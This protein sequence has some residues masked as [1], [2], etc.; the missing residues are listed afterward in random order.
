MRRNLMIA[1]ACGVAMLASAAPAEMTVEDVIAKHVAARGGKEAWSKIETIKCTGTFTAFSEVD[2]FTMHK[3]RGDM[4]HMDHKLNGAPVL[5][6]NDGK[7]PWQDSQLF[8]QGGAQPLTGPD[9][10]AQLREFDFV[11]PLFEVAERGYAVEL[12]GETEY[13]GLPAI[14]IKLTRTDDSE[15][16]WYLDPETYL[17]MARTSPGSDFGRPM[18]QRTFFDDFRAVSG[19]MIPHLTETQWYTRDRVM[20]IETIEVNVPI[21]DALFRMPA[22]PGMADLIAIAGSFKVAVQQRQQP[23]APWQDS[24]STSKIDK[25]FNG[26][27]MRGFNTTGGGTEIH[28]DLAYD[29]ARENYR[30]TRINDQQAYIDVLVGKFDEDGRLV[31]SN[32]D[33]GTPLEMFGMTIFARTSIFDITDEG[34]KVETEASLDGGE[35]WW[36][37]NKQTYS[38]SEE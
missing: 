10:A 1:C 38:R 31:L 9:L 30:M 36:V 18:E 25:V 13:E 20:R 15:E 16:T 26:A 34:F 33:T 14:G 27:L 37:A 35:N 28:W 3:K 8:S 17:E 24:E 23:G 11:N 21:E 5:I 19:V 2:R 7:T 12:I 29:Q 4:Y 6:G 32:L 22:P